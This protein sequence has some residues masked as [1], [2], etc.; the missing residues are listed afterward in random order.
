MTT[1]YLLSII[2]L[3]SIY[4]IGITRSQSQPDT[5]VITATIF[6]H[7]PWL[8]PDF[9]YDLTGGKVVPGLV[10]DNI[11]KTGVPQFIGKPGDGAI[12]NANTFAQWFVNTPNVNIQMD[13]NLTLTRNQTDK[14]KYY[15][16]DDYFFPIDNKG[17]DAYTNNFGAPLYKRYSNGTTFHNFHFCLHVSAAFHFQGTELFSFAGDDDVW[18]YIN[19]SLVVDLGGIHQ[20]S[21]KTVNF[22][23]MGI[24]KGDLCDF[25]FFYCERH[26]VNS[27]CEI[28][29]E[30]DFICKYYDYCGVCQG[31]GSC[32][33][34]D[35]DCNDN[36]P[37]TIDS[38]PN[39]YTNDTLKNGNWKNYCQHTPVVCA[40]YNKCDL[41]SCN[42]AT[43]KCDHS[44][45]QC[46]ARPCFDATCN[47]TLGCQYTAKNCSIND[48]CKSSTCDANS[49]NCVSKDIDCNDNDP[50][51]VD[52]CDSKVG[53]QHTPMPCGECKQCNAG[54]CQEIQGCQSCSSPCQSPNDLCKE[55]FCLN[56][57]TCSI[58]DK[59]GSDGNSCTIDSCDPSDGSI[60]H[61]LMDCASSADGCHTAQCVEGQCVS[62][63]VNC[64]DGNVCT[65][66]SCANGTCVFAANTCD[67]G[68]PCTVDSC[69]E[70]TGCINTPLSCPTNNMCEV[71]SCNST[72][73]L[74]Q[75]APRQCPQPSDF[76]RVAVCDNTVGCVEIDRP[77][78]ADDPSCQFGRC[79]N[80]SNQCEFVNYTPL[81]FRC[82]ST[83]VKVG[84][85][86]GAAAIA[87]IILAGAVAIGLAIFGGKKGYEYWKM[88]QDQRIAGSNNNPLYEPSPNNQENP[89][90]RNK[91]FM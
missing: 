82:Q 49:G 35:R 83:A 32:C 50:C 11:Q 37:C 1:R 30:L 6:D 46:D 57:G 53:C 15:F 20:M 39:D 84:V 69:S 24:Q 89:L 59:S 56:N 77:C 75:L 67:D 61:V 9:E 44:V 58:R 45:R 8:N 86:I 43:G 31:I 38:C 70:Q 65:I 72:S 2:L 51:T 63:P 48:V 7:H 16:L 91:S 18:V 76:C 88:S 87:G 4:I 23:E 47:P 27:E 19:K 13:Y 68:N 25:D 17:W 85:S 5:K 62:T 81:P 12:T 41:T 60:K 54:Q 34:P 26:T 74:C 73:G 3:C 14:T 71:A 55:A 90:Y 40:P 36:N 29:T 66:D 22:S 79:N 80:V 78:I 64:S 21:Y 33:S 42:S 52:T 28:V 10:S